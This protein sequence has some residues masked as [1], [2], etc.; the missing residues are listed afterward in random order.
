M[1]SMFGL[2]ICV[3]ESIIDYPGHFHLVALTPLV[4][5]VVKIDRNLIFADL[6]L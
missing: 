6:C 5:F 1:S 4:K 3:K 2:W